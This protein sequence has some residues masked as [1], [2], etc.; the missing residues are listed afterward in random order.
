[1]LGD[2]APQVVAFCLEQ[3]NHYQAPAFR[4]DNEDADPFIPYRGM[5]Q[6]DVPA[7]MHLAQ[8][9]EEEERW[10]IDQITYV[11]GLL[12]EFKLLAEL[13]LQGN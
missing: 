12:Q 5:S 6:T 9:M 3:E 8:V 13:T 11:R 7:G 2:A 4:Y 1:M 10:A